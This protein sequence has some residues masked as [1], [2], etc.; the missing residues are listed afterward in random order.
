MITIIHINSPSIFLLQPL[1]VG[2]IVITIIAI[3]VFGDGGGGVESVCMT[4]V[5]DG[6]N[7]C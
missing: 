4:Q 3:V 5:V 2:V 6:P 1:L 7:G